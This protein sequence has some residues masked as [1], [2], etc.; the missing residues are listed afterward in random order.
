MG[1]VTYLAGRGTTPR[2]AP[3]AGV[4]LLATAVCGRPCPTSEPYPHVCGYEL[5]RDPDGK[6]NWITKHQCVACSDSTIPNQQ[7]T[8]DAR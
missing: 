3:P 4:W 1:T 2:P 7:S 5:R 6:R 8:G